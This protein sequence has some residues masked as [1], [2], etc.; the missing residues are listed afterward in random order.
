MPIVTWAK[1]E[2]NGKSGRSFIKSIRFHGKV[3]FHGN[4]FPDDTGKLLYHGITTDNKI[5]FKKGEKYEKKK[6]LSTASRSCDDPRLCPVQSEH[7]SGGLHQHEISQDEDH[8]IHPVNLKQVGSRLFVHRRRFRGPYLRQRR[9]HDPGGLHQ[10]MGKGDG[11]LER[12][13]LRQ[14]RVHPAF[15]FPEHVLYAPDAKGHGKD[16]GLQ[17]LQSQ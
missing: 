11:A 16:G 13:H 1:N 4:N 6:T 8:G 17:P 9:L 5:F 10:R 15:Q 7:R 2:R 3:S 14:G 12:L